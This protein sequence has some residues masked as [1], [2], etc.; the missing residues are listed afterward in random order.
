MKTCDGSGDDIRFN[1]C[2]MTGKK[3]VTLPT[4]RVYSIG[5]EELVSNIDKVVD[6]SIFLPRR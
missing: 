1:N 6:V 2:Y 4:Y 5:M 3:T